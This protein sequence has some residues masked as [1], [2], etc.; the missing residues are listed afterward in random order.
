MHSKLPANTLEMQF[1][2]PYRDYLQAPLQPLMDN[3]ESQ[4]YETFE[5]DPVK[6]VQY[7]KAVTLALRDITAGRTGDNPGTENPAVVMVVGAGRGPLV[8]AVLVAAAAAPRKVRV[9]AVE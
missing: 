3:L 9:F 8:R 1:E 2:A 7:E 6:Y 5:R 4:T